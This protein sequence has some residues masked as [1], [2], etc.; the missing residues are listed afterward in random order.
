[1]CPSNSVRTCQVNFE[2]LPLD[3]TTEG[4]QL[5]KEAARLRGLSAPR[6][7]SSA[8]RASERV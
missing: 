4:I 1:M 8:G 6:P 5:G 7:K 3:V 2:K